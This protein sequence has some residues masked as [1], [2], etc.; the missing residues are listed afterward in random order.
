[1][2]T[3]GVSYSLF[4][5]Y[6]A[7]LMGIAACMIL[8]FHATL[9]NDY[10]KIIRLDPI[11]YR[12][13]CGVDIFLLLSGIGCYYSFSK[14]PSVWKFW[15]KRIIT[16][17]PVSI[18]LIALF[19]CGEILLKTKATPQAIIDCLKLGNTNP[20]WYVM[21]QM[22]LYLLFPLFYRIAENCRWAIWGI[23]SCIVVFEFLFAYYA[24][25]SY[26][27]VEISLT[28]CPPFLIGILYGQKAK[29][30]EHNKH[31]YLAF[32]CAAVIFFAQRFVKGSASSCLQRLA[33]NMN[34]LC[35]C[36][37]FIFIF[38]LVKNIRF[39]KHFLQISSFVGS[40]SLELY[41]QF[42]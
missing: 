24:Y 18:I 34:G 39:T 4:S 1:M 32:V 21:C 25:D 23:I 6:K 13:N 29:R 7:Q 36:Y 14:S 8:A 42:A 17:L 15:Q 11:L 10:I 2:R 16:I 19:I 35:I 38:Q 41:L 20:A 12:L 9:T 40:M 31:W 37:I 26:Q 27:L 5:K 28:R 33:C 30:D 3:R 22:L